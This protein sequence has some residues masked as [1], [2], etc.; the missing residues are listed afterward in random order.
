MRKK[1]IVYHS[2][3]S[4]AHTGFGR[5]SKELLGYLY[6][7]GKYDIVEY[8]AGAK[9]SDTTCKRTPWKCFGCWPD[10]DHELAH[11]HN[12][13]QK[14]AIINHVRYG[15]HNIDKI[16]K[17][18]KPDIYIGAEDFWAFAGYWER[19]W[20][21]KITT[22]IHTTLD[23][24][25]LYKPC[26]ENASKPTHLRVWAKFAE[27]EFLRLADQEEKKLEDCI[28]KKGA[29]ESEL[30]ESRKNIDS[31][32]NVKTIHGAI[33]C[34]TFRKLS[35]AEK[36]NLR[37]R[38]QIDQDSY[39]VGFVFRNQLRKQVEALLE[40]LAL[41]K[42]E[43]P[44]VK[45]KV[46]LHTNWEEKDKGWDI[47]ELIK[48]HSIDNS[49][50]LTTYVCRNCQEYEVK[51]FCG[52]DSDCRFC[53]EKAKKQTNGGE[54][55]TGQTTT[56]GDVSVSERQLNEIYNLMNLYVHPFSSGGQE[57]PV[58]EAKL[59]QLI[60][61]VT[62]YSC[63]TEYCTEESGGLSLDWFKYLEHGSQFIKASTSSQS[64][65]RQVVKCLSFDKNK[66]EEMGRRARQFVIENCSVKVVGGEF[67]KLI[68]DCPFVDWEKISLEEVKCN[69]EYPF[70]QEEDITEFVASLY[71]NILNREPD[72][73]GFAHWLNFIN[74]HGNGDVNN[75]RVQ[76]YQYFIGEARQ[77][78]AKNFPK[79]LKLE[80]PDN[81]R[82][83]AAMVMPQSIGDCYLT[84][85]LFESFAEQYPDYDL[86]MVTKPEFFEVFRANPYI[87]KLIPFQPNMENE[88]FWIGQG[89]HKGFVD[90]CFLPFVTTQKHLNY[91]GNGNNN[92]AYD[93]YT[94]CN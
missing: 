39:V 37:D 54:E 35:S 25:P 44:N 12:H 23:R 88:L 90:I 40:S 71:K 92:I 10:N 34:E 42:K 21:D 17:Q 61:L 6:K 51:S 3:S 32:R 89:N 80:F 58:Q 20:W 41:L 55:R 22:V 63:G 4:W 45:F 53:G 87:Y 30:I 64:I 7:T 9:W 19:K 68:D 49:D 67:E 48:R 60:T 83:K 85:S 66:I 84:T 28:L 76:A 65:K 2:N 70:P 31:Y 36:Q 62:N 8:A 46:L 56:G 14:D 1:K 15:S 81:G 78:N 47:P 82:K 74:S 16:I 5:A 50:V 59:T 18:E 93:I 52:H 57:I 26:V 43:K 13:P 72:Q 27:E 94:K 79:D 24:L 69:S 11:I 73:E 33:S 75:K 38:N 29:K 91:L 77:Q 86:Y